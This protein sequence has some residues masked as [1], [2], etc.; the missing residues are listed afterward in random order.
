MESFNALHSII[1][2][3]RESHLRHRTPLNVTPAI[4]TP[5]PLVTGG[6]WR[7]RSPYTV[8]KYLPVRRNK[9]EKCNEYKFLWWVGDAFR[10]TKGLETISSPVTFI[11]INGIVKVV[12]PDLRS[13][14]LSRVT[15]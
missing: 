12:R 6:S 1:R 3:Q 11:I 14:S 2:G 7:Y 13:V 4:R 15:R 8:R 10:R 5:P 9:D